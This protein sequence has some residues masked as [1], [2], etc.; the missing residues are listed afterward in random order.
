M[1]LAQMF[2]FAHTGKM[3]KLYLIKMFQALDPD[4]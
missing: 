1:F 4:L 2:E 3:G